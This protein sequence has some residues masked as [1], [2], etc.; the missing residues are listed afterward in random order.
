MQM[1][2][3]SR[4]VVS[5]PNAE[6]AEDPVEDIVGVNRAGD[7]PQFVEGLT[8]FNRQKLLI[9]LVAGDREGPLESGLSFDQT[10][11]AAGGRRAD[12][13]ARSGGGS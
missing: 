7:L 11:A 2:S 4:H 5:L 8:D 12:E 10:I 13:L 9:F 6:P 1:H 3:V